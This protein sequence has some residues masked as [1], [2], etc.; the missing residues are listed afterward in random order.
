MLDFGA[1]SYLKIETAYYQ[2]ANFYSM[3]QYRALL[4][5]ADIF[6]D[7]SEEDLETVAEIC[8]LEKYAAGEMVIDENSSG[9]ELYVIGQGEV[10]ILVN[11]TLVS[12]QIER[13]HPS[14]VIATLRRGQSFGEIA[15]VDDGLRSATARALE[16]HTLLLVIQRKELIDLCESNLRVGYLLMRNLASDL[17][18]KVR[19]ADLQIRESLL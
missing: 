6:Y 4:K 13:L 9:N 2:F 19:S 10:E 1:S 5:Q 3:D 8:S 11:P 18:L 14:S 17:A 7:F 12:D 16:D 15:L